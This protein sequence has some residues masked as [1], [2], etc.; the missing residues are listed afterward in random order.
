VDAASAL[1]GNWRVTGRLDSLGLLSPGRARKE[2]AIG[3]V[4]VDRDAAFDP[5][6]SPYVDP[7]R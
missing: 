1:T 2:A 6:S 7:L 5:D 4:R 3:T